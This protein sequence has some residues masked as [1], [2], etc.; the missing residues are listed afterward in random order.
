MSYLEYFLYIRGAVIWVNRHW[1][2]VGLLAQI[3]L[4]KTLICYST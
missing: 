3:R 2:S 4:I 1:P